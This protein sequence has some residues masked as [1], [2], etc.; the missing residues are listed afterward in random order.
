MLLM[1]VPLLLLLPVSILKYLDIFMRKFLFMQLF[2][3]IIVTVCIYL[4]TDYGRGLWGQLT[5]ELEIYYARKS[6]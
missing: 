5:F 6:V 2:H 4:L 1:K 3:G